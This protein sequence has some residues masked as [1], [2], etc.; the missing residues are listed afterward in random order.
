MGRLTTHV[1]DTAQGKPA[2]AVAITLYRNVGE[3]YV[4]VKDAV[5]NADGRCA[6]PLLEG[7]AFTVGRYRL[8]FSAGAYFAEKGV[9][10]PNPPFVDIVTID[11]GVADGSAHYHVPL[12]VSPWSW[13]TYR[14]S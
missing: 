7:A 9:A 8:V 1:L 11:F 10:L 14:G 2:A 5:T 3:R 6:E 13:S 12:L 4:L